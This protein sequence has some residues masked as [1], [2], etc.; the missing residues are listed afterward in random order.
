MDEKASKY[1]AVETA[2]SAVVNG[3][4]N[5]GGCIRDLSQP[6]PGSCNRTSQSAERFDRRNIFSNRIERFSSFTHRTAA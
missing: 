1:L 2:G 3:I 6:Q 4:L 5:L